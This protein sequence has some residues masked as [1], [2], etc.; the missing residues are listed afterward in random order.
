MTIDRIAHSGAWRI[1][2]VHDSHLVTRVYFF[3]T[4][5]EAIAAFRAEIG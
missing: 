1:S 5:R 3:M 2:A 4:K